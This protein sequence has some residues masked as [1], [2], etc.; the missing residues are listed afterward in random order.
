MA[1]NIHLSS[2]LHFALLAKNKV[3]KDNLDYIQT[4]ILNKGLTES[5]FDP[6]FIEYLEDIT[7]RFTYPDYAF[8]AYIN[9]LNEVYNYKQQ[10]LD[11]M[12]NQNTI[13]LVSLDNANLSKK[14]EELELK[15]NANQL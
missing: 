9:N 6:V 4:S 2:D 8:R 7:N 10:L 12:Y 3:D 11:H 14:I 15:C 1:V 13:N 5:E